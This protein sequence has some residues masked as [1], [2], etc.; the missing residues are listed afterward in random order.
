MPSRFANGPR[1]AIRSGFAGR[2]P[3]GISAA[4]VSR[5]WCL[6]QFQLSFPAQLG[7][8]LAPPV[9]FAKRK[10]IPVKGRGQ[11]KYP[12]AMFNWFHITKLKV[13]GKPQ[14]KDIYPQIIKD[15][16]SY[17]MPLSE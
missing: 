17:L 7:G 8:Y 9:M 16:K 2:K 3:S 4:M 1:G 10:G 11:I 14:G 13:D 12:A 5:P 15:L 6:G